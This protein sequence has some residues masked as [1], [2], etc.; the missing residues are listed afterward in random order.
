[1]WWQP[2]RW[3]FGENPPSAEEHV[4]QGQPPQD[5]QLLPEDKVPPALAARLSRLEAQNT[6]MRMAIALVGILAPAAML[7]MG[8]ATS[9]PKR[10]TAQ[11]FL[12][13]DEKGELVR[14]DREGIVIRNSVTRN[15]AAR[16]SWTYSGCLLLYDK[17]EKQ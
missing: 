17:D 4:M 14:I 7:L 1:M 13:E 2:G 6:R 5:R 3:G 9:S 8:Q 15:M 16:L 12:V 11:E 10:I